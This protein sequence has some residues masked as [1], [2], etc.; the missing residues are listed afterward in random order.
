MNSLALLK[1]VLLATVGV[2]AL[3]GTARPAAAAPFYF[4]TITAPPNWG[5]GNPQ[6]LA[7]WS[8]RT[9]LLPGPPFA[10]ENY[11]SL[12]LLGYPGYW[13]S[14][15]PFFGESR[16][17][18]GADVSIPTAQWLTPAA[19]TWLGGPAGSGGLA[20]FNSFNPFTGVFYANMMIV[21]DPAGSCSPASACLSDFETDLGSTSGSLT[22]SLVTLD[23]SGDPLGIT[24][25]RD[26][27]DPS[28]T[29]NP[30][31]PNYFAS[32]S[33]FAVPEGPSAIYLLLGI[34]VL[35]AGVIIRRPGAIPLIGQ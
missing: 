31:G 25:P 12:A 13:Y 34:F 28:V 1:R 18:V 6:P 20:F 32:G 15:D 24:P 27:D 17:F 21:L 26:D 23:G 3:L 10:A 2:I 16:G 33:Q 9:A 35:G 14:F 22:P 7:G 5:F 8:A 19:Y 4:Y 29:P 11:V 30:L